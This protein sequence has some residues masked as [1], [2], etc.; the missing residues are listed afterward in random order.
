M[1]QIR[2]PKH[3]WKI[4]TYPNI[5][6]SCLSFNPI[7]PILAFIDCGDITV[8]AFGVE[9]KQKGQIM[10]ATRRVGESRYY[11]INW[12]P[13]GEYP[14]AL[15]GKETTT[16][17]FLWYDAKEKSISE[18]STFPYENFEMCSGLNTKHLWVDKSTIMFASAQRY[19]MSV[20]KISGKEKK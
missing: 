15:R 16:I 7:H 10:Y 19:V 1:D 5:Y 12:S 8:L 20:I 4:D 2:K 17:S 3:D 18:V 11:G 9:R 6:I 13:S 14:L